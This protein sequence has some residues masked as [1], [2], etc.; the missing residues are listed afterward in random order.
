MNRLKTY[1][2][3]KLIDRDGKEFIVVGT[4]YY[5]ST[6]LIKP[7]DAS[8]SSTAAVPLNTSELQLLRKTK[9]RQI[10]LEKLS[11]FKSGDI[12]IPKKTCTTNGY[13][14][15]KTDIIP[16]KI[17]SLDYINLGKVLITIERGLNYIKVYASA[18]KLV[19]KDEDAYEIF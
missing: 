12:I 2:I 18:F 6:I 9:D 14:F 3:V 13:K 16:Y 8:F 15:K 19:I 1:D 11:G 7:Y 10:T 17:D 5:T 4:D